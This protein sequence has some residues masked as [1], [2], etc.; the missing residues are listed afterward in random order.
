MIQF[1]CN[2]KYL[3]GWGG[4]SS[5]LFELVGAFNKN[6]LNHDFGMGRP[7]PVWKKLILIFMLNAL[8]PGSF[9]HSFRSLLF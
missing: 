9:S 8:N 5:S 1:G 3:P 4:L 6:H 2:N 7:I